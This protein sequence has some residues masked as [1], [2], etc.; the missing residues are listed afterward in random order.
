[1][2]FRVSLRARAGRLDLDLE[3]DGASA[4]TAVI[5]PNGSGKTSLLRLIAGARQ[6]IEGTIELFG[7]TLFDS[8]RRLNVPSEQR[9]V[10]YVPQGYGLFPH[11][12]VLDNVSFGL[13]VGLNQRHSSR[14]RRDVAFSLLEELGCSHLGERWPSALSGGEQQ[15]VALA[16]ALIVDPQI[17]LLDEP[18]AA[19]DA[20]A[21]RRLRGFLAERLKRRDKPSIVVTH[22]LCDVLALDAT[23]VVIEG[24]KVVQRGSV[25][26]IER[27]PATDFVAEFVGAAR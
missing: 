6:P 3:L 12:N 2:S 27:A 9:G 21:R 7:R 25:A 10:G 4:V 24:G 17:L 26:D 18:L 5:G 13:S 8:V 23:V 1:M 16:R 11:L 22:Q 20:A 15:R 14:A 19:L